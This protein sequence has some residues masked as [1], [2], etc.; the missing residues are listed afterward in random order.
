MMAPFG[1]EDGSCADVATV[2]VW[3]GGCPDRSPAAGGTLPGG[4]RELLVGMGWPHL[5]RA[6]ACEGE[7]KT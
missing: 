1:P 4:A 6:T 5:K 3:W 2:G 7:S